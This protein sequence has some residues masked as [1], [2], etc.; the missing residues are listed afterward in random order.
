MLDME[1]RRLLMVISFSLR[2]VCVTY[3]I[4]FKP[5]GSAYPPVDVS[6]YL[7]KQ[8]RALLLCDNSSSIMSIFGD[9]VENLG[10]RELYT[11]V[12]NGEHIFRNHIRSFLNLHFIVSTNVF[13]KAMVEER[14]NE[15]DGL[16]QMFL[17][18][19]PCPY[20]YSNEII[21]DSRSYSKHISMTVLLYCIKKLHFI[22]DPGLANL[23]SVQYFQLHYTFDKES[24][25]RLNLFHTYCKKTCEDFQNLAP[26]IR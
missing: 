26:F 25:N 19:C 11:N 3:L 2:P 15:I 8:K 20:V 14:E 12:Y 17:S 1:T 5:L 22:V 4:H 9:L 6:R 18:S 7:K 21:V 23:K 10:D 16:M 24:K 13:I